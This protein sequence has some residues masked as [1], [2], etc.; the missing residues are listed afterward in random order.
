M[1][2]DPATTSSPSEIG[3]LEGLASTRAIVA[4][5]SYQPKNFVLEWTIPQGAEEADGIDSLSKVVRDQI[6]DSISERAH[7]RG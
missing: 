1:S 7:L 2:T 4:T 3:L 5:G 6:D